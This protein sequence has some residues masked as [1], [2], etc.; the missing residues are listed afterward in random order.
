[1]R[2]K[3]RTVDMGLVSSTMSSLDQD[4][5]LK[6]KKKTLNW[7]EFAVFKEEPGRE[8]KIWTDTN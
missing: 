6:K 1:M 5:E 8:K 3:H 7:I 4:T 2:I